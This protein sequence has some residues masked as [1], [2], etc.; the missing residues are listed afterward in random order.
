MNAMDR[1][2]HFFSS[3]LRSSLFTL[4][5]TLIIVLA[6]LGI[7]LPNEVVLFTEPIANANS[8]LAMFMLGCM[9]SFAVSRERLVSMAKLLSLRVAFSIAF[10]CLIW[11]VLPCDGTL[12]AVLTLLVWG[13]AS[14]LAPMYTHMS[15]ADGGLAG[16][17]NAVTIILGVIAA[18]TI[19]LTLT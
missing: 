9:M 1:I 3:P 6:V 13:P 12:K 8:F 16:F 19:A 15:G 4:C 2:K 10:T 7:R 14:A 5:V 18:T 17:A 11:A